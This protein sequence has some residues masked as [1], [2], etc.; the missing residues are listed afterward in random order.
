MGSPIIGLPLHIALSEKVIIIYIVYVLIS[1]D[2]KVFIV[3]NKGGKQD[4]NR[5]N[6]IRR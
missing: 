2:S 4:G 3:V 5:T 1:F 6:P